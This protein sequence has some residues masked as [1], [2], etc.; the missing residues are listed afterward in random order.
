M[1]QNLFS[2]LIRSIVVLALAASVVLAGEGKMKAPDSLKAE[3]TGDQLIQLDWTDAGKATQFA[4]YRAE[5]HK[6]SE[7]LDY[8]GLKFTNV[9]SAEEAKF[10]DGFLAAGETQ[11]NL[12]VMLVYYVTA[13]GKDGLE[14]NRSNYAEVLLSPEASQ[15]AMK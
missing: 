14:S 5:I 12:P 13:V 4:V 3:L 15:K 7:K 2:S 11:D 9:G 1:K 8:S 10:S 6:L